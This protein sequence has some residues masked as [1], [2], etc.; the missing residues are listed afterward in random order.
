MRPPVGHPEGNVTVSNRP[1]VDSRLAGRA[2]AAG[3]RGT[4]LGMGYHLAAVDPGDSAPTDGA[5]MNWHPCK[6]HWDTSVARS[7]T[8][9]SRPVVPSAVCLRRSPRHIQR[10]LIAPSARGRGDLL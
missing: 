7:E 5:G 8:R 2:P 4:A 1:G 3:G 9:G 10:H 6:L